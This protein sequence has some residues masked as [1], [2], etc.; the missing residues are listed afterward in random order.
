MTYRF[1]VAG[2]NPVS[3]FP[4][5]AKRGKAEIVKDVAG[6]TAESRSDQSRAEGSVN[7][8]V[9]AREGSAEPR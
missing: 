4:S 8:R 5:E 3:S 9:S 2:S 1:A 7:T 6:G